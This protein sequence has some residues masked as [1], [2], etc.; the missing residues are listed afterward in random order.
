MEQPGGSSA[1]RRVKPDGWFLWEKLGEIPGDPPGRPLEIGINPPGRVG[2]G[3]KPLGTLFVIVEA[4]KP[5]KIYLPVA[6][7][8]G[9]PD[10][11]T[12]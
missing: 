1:C 5:D 6:S 12:S 9:F 11:D 8:H 3:I 7:P 2:E 10:I 4:R